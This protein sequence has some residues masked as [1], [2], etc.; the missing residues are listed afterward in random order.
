MSALGLYQVAPGIPVYTLG[1]P[2][3]DRAIIHAQHAP[4]EIEVKDNSPAN[5]YVKRV[6]L[7]GKELDAPFISHEEIARGGKL[8]FEMS[9]TH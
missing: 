2:M 1:R 6:L 7:N 3:V 9:D 8:V 5:M 4:F